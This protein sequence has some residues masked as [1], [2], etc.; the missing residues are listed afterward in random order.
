MNLIENYYKWNFNTIILSKT[1]I[2]SLRYLPKIK[3]LSLFFIVDIKQY[4][5]NLLLFYI[6][7]NLIFTGILLL[8]KKEIQNFYVFHLTLKKKKI[9]FFLLNFINVYLPLLSI[10]P[11]LIIKKNISSCLFVKNK[12]LL[13]RLNYFNF[14]IINELEILYQKSYLITKFIEAYKLQIDIYIKTSTYL[15]NTLEFIIRMYRVPCILNYKI[16]II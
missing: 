4:K 15:K 12:L 7:I 9:F 3:K 8:K 13:Y 16:K 10:D 6:L 11:K 2:F 14:P 1:I 5:K